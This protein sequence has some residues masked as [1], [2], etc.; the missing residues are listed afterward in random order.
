MAGG[1]KKKKS[2]FRYPQQNMA[3]ASGDWLH[4][5]QE[6]GSW[7]PIPRLIVGKAGLYY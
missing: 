6:V 5:G 2:L 1:K 7:P 3:T 4:L